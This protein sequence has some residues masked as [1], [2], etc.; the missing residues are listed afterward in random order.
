MDRCDPVEMRKNLEVVGQLKKA[1][2][3][4]VA[5]PAKDKDHKAQLI[6][7]TQRVFEHLVA[8]EDELNI[9]KVNIT[10]KLKTTQQ[11]GNIS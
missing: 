8:L 11:K 6:A 5:I 7:Q 4:F 3:D 9:N 10:A 2:I 1:G